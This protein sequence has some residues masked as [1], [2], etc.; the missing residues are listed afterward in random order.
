[1][2]LL[3]THG[4]N[5]GSRIFKEGGEGQ[6]RMDACGH[7]LGN[8]WKTISSFGEE[9]TMHTILSIQRGVGGGG[10]GGRHTTRYIFIFL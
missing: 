2:Q 3:L 9:L 1:M 6:N 8:V 10:G 7:G 4:K 5:P